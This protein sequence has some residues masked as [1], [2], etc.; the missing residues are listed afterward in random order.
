MAEAKSN[1]GNETTLRKLWWGG[2]MRKKSSA[3]L[4]F[5]L[6]LKILSNKKG[7]GHI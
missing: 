1:I 6:S 7:Q 3:K 2:G 5:D 4:I